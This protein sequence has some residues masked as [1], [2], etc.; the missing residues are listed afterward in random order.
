MIRWT[1]MVDPVYSLSVLAG[2]D[3]ETN[4]ITGINIQQN[5]LIVY[6]TNSNGSNMFVS[7]EY[8]L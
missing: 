7:K 4:T 6:Y 5:H 2:I 8:E 1:D 3:P